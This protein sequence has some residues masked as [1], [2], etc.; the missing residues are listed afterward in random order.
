MGKSGF[1]FRDI[2]EKYNIFGFTNKFGFENENVAKYFNLAL[3]ADNQKNALEN[4]E[5]LFNHLNINPQNAIFMNQVHEDDICVVNEE[6]MK[7]FNYDKTQ[8]SYPKCDALIT[9]LKNIALFVMVADC[10]PILIFDCKNYAIGAVHAGRLGVCK[11]ILTKTLN[12]M[13]ELYNSD[14]SDILVVIGPNIKGN[15]YEIQNLDLGEYN[16]FAKL[17]EAK[18]TFDLNMALKFELDNL[19][20]KK[21]YFNETCTHCDKNYFSYRRDGVTGRFCGYIM[22]RS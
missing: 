10:S 18:R 19:G 17:H 5:I 11:Q 22:M 9:N 7:N 2:L 16:Q 12:K 14:F 21:Y 20:I 4:R 13:K 1:D 15:C 8:N 6:F 3:H